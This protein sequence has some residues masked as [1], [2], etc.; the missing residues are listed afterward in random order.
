MRLKSECR[1][2][3]SPVIEF[4]QQFINFRSIFCYTFPILNW[5]GGGQNDVTDSDEIKGC[6]V[7][8]L[9]WL[10]VGFQFASDFIRGDFY[11]RKDYSMSHLT[12]TQVSPS[13]PVMLISWIFTS[14]HIIDARAMQPPCWLIWKNFSPPTEQKESGLSPTPSQENHFGKQLAS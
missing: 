9:S 8:Y 12:F 2:F 14:F 6:F 4:S 5:N 11:F 1:P 10:L 7:R 13:N 3:P